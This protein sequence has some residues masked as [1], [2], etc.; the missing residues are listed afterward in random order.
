MKRK[1]IFDWNHISNKLSDDQVKE[2][3]A[4]YASYHKKQWCYKASFKRLRKWKLAGDI[5]SILFAT[6]GIVSAVATSGVSLVAISTV[7]VFIQTYMKHKDI[8]KKTDQCRYAFQTYGHVLI[9]IKDILRS[10]DFNSH[11]FYSKI[12]HIDDFL[13]D[14]TPQVDK[15]IKRYN[16]KF[17]CQ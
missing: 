13:L 4:Y 9:E 3:K 14:N 11:D 15:Y 7:S 17:T 16:E 1:N 5:S 8:V 10:G 12:Q 6:G 2:L